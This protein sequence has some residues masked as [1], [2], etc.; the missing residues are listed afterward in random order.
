VTL[1]LASAYRDLGRT[2]EARA[3]LTGLHERKLGDAALE[4]RVA[5]A[6]ATLP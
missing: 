5:E 2:P 4:A 1:H 3:L 6:L